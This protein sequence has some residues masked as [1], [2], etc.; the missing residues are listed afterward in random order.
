MQ[1]ENIKAAEHRMMMQQK[2]NESGKLYRKFCIGGATS[3]HHINI[4]YVLKKHS[5]STTIK[6]PFMEI[7]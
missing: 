2:S 6:I 3:F 4:I 1:H 7:K 5:L